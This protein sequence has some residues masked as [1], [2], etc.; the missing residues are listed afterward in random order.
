MSTC[1]AAGTLQW[2][3]QKEVALLCCQLGKCAMCLK[4]NLKS[5]V[6]CLFC[7]YKSSL[8][9]TITMHGHWS[10]EID[11]LFIAATAAS[12]FI[13]KHVDACVVADIIIAFT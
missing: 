3:S 4:Q 9:R 7:N 6:L 12:F 5:V 10:R 8:I 2:S 1:C 13:R 11:L